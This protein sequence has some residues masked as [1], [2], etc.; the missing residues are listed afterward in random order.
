MWTVYIIQCPD[1]SLYTGITLDVAERLK[2]HVSGKGSRY[3]RGKSPLF[4]VYKENQPDRS[5]A[6]RREAQIKR[7]PHKKKRALVFNDAHTKEIF[8]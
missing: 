5:S 3:L 1:K 8:I 7:W 2:E 6:L 4:V